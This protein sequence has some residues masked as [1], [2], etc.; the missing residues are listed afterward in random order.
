[1][2]GRGQHPH[3]QFNI[4]IPHFTNNTSAEIS[5]ICGDEVKIRVSWDVT[6]FCQYVRWARHNSMA[7]LQAADEGTASSYEG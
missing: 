1:M 3:R 2:C 7:C 6:Q 4:F 5:A